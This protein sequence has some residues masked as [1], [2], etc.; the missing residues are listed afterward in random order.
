LLN[1]GADEVYFGVIGSAW[2]E[3][4][5]YDTI[6]NRRDGDVANVESIEVAREIMEIVHAAGKR[7]FLTLNNS[8]LES[9]LTLIEKEVEALLSINPDAVI[10]K[11]PLVASMVRKIDPHRT[12]HMSS[13]SQT[14]SIAAVRYWVDNHKPSRIIFPRNITAD[15]TRTI[16]NYFPELEFEIF[17][18]NDWCYNSDGYCSSLHLEGLKEG[19]PYVCNREKNFESENKVYNKTYH[20]M[21]EKTIDC[22]VCGLFELKNVSN[23]VSWKIVGREKP[24]TILAKDVAFVRSVRDYL[25][26][27]DDAREFQTFCQRRYVQVYEETCQKEHCEFGTLV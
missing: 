23:I 5:G 14:L 12:L 22:K 17:V 10:V 24:L 8:P 26:L 4:R 7:A 9:D 16:A 1:L 25:R 3:K 27:C 20:E 13:L 11:D 18:K 2:K 6:L 15:E 19:I 21:I